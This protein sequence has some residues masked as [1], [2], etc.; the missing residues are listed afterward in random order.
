MDSYGIGRDTSKAKPLHDV[1]RDR[2]PRGSGSRSRPALP[3]SARF[4]SLFW[5]L[6]EVV[7]GGAGMH[8]VGAVLSYQSLAGAYLRIIHTVVY[9]TYKKCVHSDDELLNWM[10][11]SMFLRNITLHRFSQSQ[12]PPVTVKSEFVWWSS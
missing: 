10:L 12:H 4:V 6:G 3:E 8:V 2:W 9:S 5:M 11:L 7:D 1:K